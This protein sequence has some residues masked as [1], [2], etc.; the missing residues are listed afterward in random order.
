[1]LSVVIVALLLGILLVA[2][3]SSPLLGAVTAQ[4]AAA[5]A[6]AVEKAPEGNF[7]PLN[8]ALLVDTRNGTGVAAAGQ[9]RGPGQ[10]TT[11]VA[12]RG[13]VP[14]TA[15]AAVVLD[16]TTTNST[17]AVSMTVWPTA[18]A[19]PNVTHH[20]TQVG[21]NISN[22]VFTELGDGGRVNLYIPGGSTDVIVRV[23][24]YFSSDDS[25]AGF[26]PVTATRVLDTRAGVGAP[27]GAIPAGGSLT[28]SLAGAGVPTS[29]AAFAANFTSIAASNGFFNVGVLGSATQKSGV[30][31][32]GSTTGSASMQVVQTADGQIEIVNASAQ[33]IQLVID[34]QGYFGAADAGGGYTPAPGPIYDTRSGSNTPIPA[35]GTITVQLTGE[36]DL[37]RRL[38]G[39]VLTDVTV[40]NPGGS[41]FLR[42]WAD[43][44]DEPGTSNV[45]FAAG[46]TR[47]NTALVS[48]R[49]PATGKMTIRNMAAVAV[50]V[51]IDAQGWFSPYYDPNPGAAFPGGPGERSFF[52]FTD[53]ALTD[54][55]RLRVNNASG[56]ALYSAADVQIAG[57]GQ[58]L[59]IGR[60]YN[61]RTTTIGAFGLGWS[62]D[63]GGDLKLVAGTG[64][65]A[66]AYDFHGPTGYV[67]RFN[68]S[69]GGGWTSPASLDATLTESGS[70][71]TVRFERTGET[72]SFTT[73]GRLSSR[74]DRNGN[75]VSYTYDAAGV[76]SSITDTRARVLSV[77]TS[78]AGRITALTDAAGRQWRYTYSNARLASSTTPDAETTSYGYDSEGRLLRVTDPRGAITALTYDAHGRAL[79]VR[80]PLSGTSGGPTYTFTY[81]DGRTRVTDANS[82][83]TTYLYDSQARVTDVTDALGNARV[84]SYNPNGNVTTFTPTSASSGGTPFSNGYS[85]DGR[86]NPTSSALPT[87]ATSTFAYTDTDNLYAPSG[88]TSPQGATISYDYDAVGNLA[89]VDDPAA[90][91]TSLQRGNGD[92][93]VTRTTDPNGSITGYGYNTAGELTSIDHP[94]P[95]GDETLEYDALSRVAAST[96]GKGQRTVYTYDTMDRV[97]SVTA[98]GGLAVTYVYDAAGNRTSTTDATGTTTT[99]LDR[100]NRV[101]AEALSVG[102]NTAYVYD[103]VGN[104]TSFSDLGGTVT[105]AYN[106]VN[107][108]ESL[109]QPGNK[110]ISFGYDSDNNRTSTTYPNGVTQAATYDA[111]SRLTR[112]GGTTA[113]GTVLTDFRYTYTTPTGGDG[114]LRRSVTDHTGAITTYGYD[115]VE[116]LDTAITRTSAG[117]VTKTYDYDYDKASNRIRTTIDNATPTAAAYN[118]ANQLCWTAPSTATGTPSCTSTPTGA[119]SYAYDANSNTTATTGPTSSGG[120]MAYSYNAFDQTTSI[121]PP[122]G[123][124][125]PAAYTGTS[126]DQRTRYTDTQGSTTRT[127]TNTYSILGLT[128]RRQTNPGA[129]HAY[130]RDPNGQVLARRIGDTDR[131]YYLSDGLGSTAATTNTS[132]TIDR[133]YTYDPYGGT[134]SSVT[135]FD[136]NP[137]RYTGEYQDNNTSHYAIGARYLNPSLGRWTQPDPL[138]GRT[139]PAQPA[140]TNPYAYVGCNPTNYTDPTGR[141]ASSCAGAVF[142]AAVGTVGFVAASFATSGI[143]FAVG[144]I[145]YVGS[146]SGVLSEC[147]EYQQQ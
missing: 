28:V 141:S 19:R 20:V 97:K 31:F 71:L 96:D 56:N 46:E 15:V 6:D 42:V 52:T 26:K 103:G 55:A 30:T 143:G 25:A 88:Y 94:A 101:T 34:V 137:W 7:V 68:P 89:T 23:V 14:S 40:A 87:G 123:A 95:R 108:V 60:H 90:G 73:A 70:G 66:G 142:F 32:A 111:S 2:P 22:M 107:L 134:T 98:P 136:T 33:P 91:R 10:L 119:T 115:T 110:T 63:L 48:A 24:G 17:A 144:A 127:F 53:F 13:G 61:S 86:N 139:N 74:D 8:Q 75:R 1:M 121:T 38:V 120:G 116:R 49:E 45:N 57:L 80:R 51:R 102:G 106:P 82:T 118:S 11:T 77:T 131:E 62:G 85:N 67:A 4:A 64:S 43:G 35:G 105:Y 9:L 128:T 145:G 44:Q 125:A 18:E 37:P 12:G 122:G 36:G 39:A 27:V 54:R 78:T 47:T 72:W 83:T 100:L 129:T 3:P 29:A 76:L 104:L 138:E 147:E 146:I 99:T 41:G 93:N 109:I 21:K 79:S 81:Q 140:E 50:E 69:S 65:A 133:R 59:A 117:A 112:I 58:D 124:A 130:T 126:Q 132:G 5:E 92:G 135:G 84:S 16:V 113:A 114:A